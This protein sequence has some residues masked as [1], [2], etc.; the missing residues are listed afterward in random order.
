MFIKNSTLFSDKNFITSLQTN[1]FC[2]LY[3]SFQNIR[4]K[5]IRKMQRK[6]PLYFEMECKSSGSLNMKHL[7]DDTKKAT[8]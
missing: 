4:A 8:E 2:D 1:P 6:T 3:T 5:M 7:S